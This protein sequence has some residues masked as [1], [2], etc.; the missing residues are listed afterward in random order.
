[1]SCYTRFA[2]EIR[3]SAA[4]LKLDLAGGSIAS[5][6]L[7]GAS[8]NPLNWDSAVHDG[9]DPTSQMPRPLGHF[10][11]CDRWGPPSEAEEANG[12]TYHGEASGV[13]WKVFGEQTDRSVSLEAKLSMAGLEVRKELRMI[14]SSALVVVTETVTNVQELGRMYNVVQHPSI[15]APF[16]SAS[17]TVDCNG[18]RGFTQGPNRTFSPTPTEPTL[19]FPDANNFAG[20]RVNARFMTGGDDDVVSYEVSPG[21]SLGWICATNPEEGLLLG[22]MWPASDYP[23]ISL[24]C[25][26]R[27]GIPMARGLEF[28][29]TGLHQPFPIL[30][31]HPRLLDLPTF[32]FIDTGESQTRSYA[33]FL[34][35]V[36]VGFQGVQELS[37]DGNR[38][39]LVERGSNRSLEMQ[40]SDG[41]FS[42]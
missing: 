3:N 14:G 4:S 13:H 31:Q 1:M 36:P 12:M 34:L 8:I 9:A 23:W 42:V 28:G 5:F 15:A 18:K 25:C 20:E 37:L 33:C 29:T 24:W 30:A 26:S 40:A 19:A 32:A 35:E 22:Y 27:G 17:T 6:Q 7:H 39:V 21:S 38:I 41:L 11:C 2:T 10:L 16:L